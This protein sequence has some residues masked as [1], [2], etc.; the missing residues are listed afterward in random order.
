MPARLPIVDPQ[1]THP[2][3]HADTPEHPSRQ[4]GRAAAAARRVDGPRL[5]RRGAVARLWR[6]Q[7]RLLPRARSLPPRTP[8]PPPYIPSASLHPHHP[9]GPTPSSPSAPHLSRSAF[10]GASLHVRVESPSPAEDRPDTRRWRVPDKDDCP[11]AAAAGQLVVGSLD[12]DEETLRSETQGVPDK[13]DC[14]AAAAASSSRHAGSWLF[15]RRRKL[16]Y[17]T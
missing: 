11:A 14:P 3:R 8:P 5:R 1:H 2:S 9:T 7:P 12:G 13:D 10:F 6:Q 16:R 17:G 4:T 15:R